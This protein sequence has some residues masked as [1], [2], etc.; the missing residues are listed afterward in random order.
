MSLLL[1]KSELIE[2]TGFIKPKKQVE[3][4]RDNGF[5]HLKIGR[6]NFPR[7]SR[8]Y[9]DQIMGCEDVERKPDSPEPNFEALM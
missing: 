1:T 4:L 5:P 9:F 7:I 6:D 8:K 3:W 2:L